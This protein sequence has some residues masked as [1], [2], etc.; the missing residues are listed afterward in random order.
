VRGI[1]SSILIP[2]G[3]VLTGICAFG[4]GIAVSNRSEA[5]RAK[6]SGL[7]FLSTFTDT[8]RQAG[9]TTR[10][11]QGNPSRRQYILEANGTGVAFVDYD[12]DGLP[13][14]FLVN[15]TTFEPHAPGSPPP[16]NALWHNE[17]NGRFRDVTGT[18]GTGR[19]GWGNGVCA[20]DYDNDGFVDLYVT[21]WGRNSLFRNSGKG[22]FND[23]ATPA[24]VAGSGSEWSTGCT[25]VD[26]DRDGLL[27][28]FVVTYAG[29]DP[30][31]VPLP[32]SLPTCRYRDRAVF[33]GPR[34]LPH[35]RAFLYRNSGDGK[36]T[37]VSERSGVRKVEGFYGFTTVAA[38][39]NGDGWQDIYVASDSTPSL[40]FRNNRN[41]TF[42]EVGT[43]SGV[44][45]NE[46]G[47]EQAGMGLAVADVNGDGTLD[48]V[49]TNFIRDY[50]NLYRN[51][52]KGI[53]EDQT[54]IAGLA[55]NPQY[56]L[57]GAGL[58]DFDNDGLP[59][60]F[61]ATGHVYSGDAAEPWATP[62]LLYR[63]LRGGK[64]E[65]VSA[66]AGRAITESHSARGAAFGDFDGDGDVD[67]LVMN[68]D[69][70]PAL[71]RNDLRGDRH[72]LQVR[73][74]GTTS[75]RSGIGATVSV[76]AGGTTQTRVVLSQSSYLS[77][78]DFRLHFGLGDSSAADSITV[79]WPS[80]KSETF[81]G[82]PADRV[83]L[84]KEGSGK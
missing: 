60:L 32:G 74:Q 59:D 20:G 75:N 19:T 38:D 36:F 24:G 63:Q 71:L 70:P 25:F 65:D 50:P 72:W 49:K 79:R 35:G 68:M 48:I 18:S 12:N 53:F 37:D 9:I 46:N 47:T 44:A 43:E 80:G 3:L 30:R 4:Q 81:P 23:V 40:L 15:G 66:L 29:F 16:S 2:V 45:F 13:D 54:L 61:L 69:E 7:P 78:N 56:L 6:A 33:C 76:A 52:G 39:F 51:L 62:R 73:L 58:E 83:V 55:V 34:G 26:F 17:G 11:V 41:G 5:P 1:P 64:F 82:G 22:T 10:F 77:V 84:L 42:S 27:D 57:W 28:L 8:A 21:Y 14:V 67:I 31:K